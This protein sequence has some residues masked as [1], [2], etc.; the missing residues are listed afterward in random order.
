MDFFA[1]ECVIMDRR[2]NQSESRARYLAKYNTDEVEHYESWIR[3]LT[4]VD[5]LACL[6]DIK[7]VFSLCVLR[8]PSNG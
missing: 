2:I 4:R 8:V 7:N 1:L 6:R 3:R 5:D